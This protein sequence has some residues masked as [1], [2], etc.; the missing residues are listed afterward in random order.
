MSR[1]QDVISMTVE[2]RSNIDLPQNM[3]QHFLGTTLNAPLTENP[4]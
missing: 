2:T 4:Q 3:S 1:F